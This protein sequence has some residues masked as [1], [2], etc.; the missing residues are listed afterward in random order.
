MTISAGAFDGKNPAGSG[1]VLK[2]DGT[3][4]SSTVDVNGTGA[5]G[6]KWY[7]TKWYGYPKTTTSQFS[8][9]S[10]GVLTINPNE[11]SN[12]QIATAAPSSNAQG[13]VGQAFGGGF[14]I[15][16][17]IALKSAQVDTTKGWPAFWSN[18]LEELTGKA[19]WPGQVTGYNHHIENDF[20]EYYG[21]SGGGVKTFG[22]ALHDWYG[23]LNKTCPG[24][25]KVTNTNGVV[26]VGAVDWTQFHTIGQLWIPGTSANNNQ[27][28]VTTYFDGVA[29][30]NVVKWVNQG[31]GVPAPS[32]TFVA[33]IQD[34]QNLVVILGTGVGSPMRVQYVRVWQLPGA[35][36]PNGT[37]ITGANQQIVDSGKNVWTLV[38]GVVYKNGAT[39]GFS[40]L[41]KKLVYSNGIVYQGTD[42]GWWGWI[43][44]N[45][46]ASGSPL[47]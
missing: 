45:W 28:S 46:V 16:G 25:C 20:F 43:N 4:S 30:P 23:L 36:S 26:Q 8:I 24:Y 37:T 32:G 47:A 5:A 17:K 3:F 35:I 29:T 6:F 19:Q 15:E 42:A 33:S 39:A 38:G 2:F 40:A 7:V 11:S 41:V 9:D 10:A 31:N 22:M 44:N 34:K 1:Y 27:G 12:Y 18:A 13:Y 21:T 14:Y